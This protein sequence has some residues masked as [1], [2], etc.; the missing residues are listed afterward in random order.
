MANSLK[1]L[2]EEYCQ[3]NKMYRLEGRKG[4]ENIA[5]LV[6]DLGYKD[7]MHFGQLNNG[8]CIGSLINFFED[9][10][11]ALEAVFDWIREQRSP[12]FYEKLQESINTECEGEDES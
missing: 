7:P 2:L 5:K 10:P 12:E 6:E 4:V 3:Q 11:G 9:N 8:A 1:R